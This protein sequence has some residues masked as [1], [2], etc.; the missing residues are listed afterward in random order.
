MESHGFLQEILQIQTSFTSG[1]CASVREHHTAWIV[2]QL[3]TRSDCVGMFC[4]GFK[5][6]ELL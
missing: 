4:H 6:L 5:K 1:S 2:K 3:P